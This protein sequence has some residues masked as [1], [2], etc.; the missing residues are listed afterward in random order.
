MIPILYFGTNSDY[1][2][3]FR[4]ILGEEVRFF[5]DLSEAFR[6]ASQHRG[7]PVVVFLER[8][9]ADEGLSFIRKAHKKFPGIYFVLVSRSLRPE[10]RASYLKAGISNAVN[11]EVTREHVDR[12]VGF[13]TDNPLLR[14]QKKK[15]DAEKVRTYRIPL[16]KRSFDVLTSSLA[17]LFLSPLLLLTMLAIRLESKGPVVYKSK[18]VGSN[19]KVFDFLKFRSMYTNADLALKKLGKLNQY[20]AQE[21]AQAEAEI[22]IGDDMLFGDDSSLEDQTLLISDDEIISETQ[23][24]TQTNLEN[25]QAFVKLENDPRITRVGRIIRKYSIDELPQLVNIFKGD[26]SVVGNRP[27]PLYEA[28]KLTSDEFIDRFMG[29]AGLTGLWQVEKRGEAGKLS[30]D[31]RKMLDIE[32]ARNYS[33]GLDM[34]IILKTFV[35]FIQK[36]N[37]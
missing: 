32:Y 30:A 8:K 2:D 18:R 25:Q 37:V 16:W 24:L 6:F 36:E 14:L 20:A 3:H 7:E 10:K 23:H 4:E 5:S 31:E 15:T 26:M 34:K 12:I 17:L 35:S 27:L 1:H 22:L 13:A 19:Y 29:P 33:F 9:S 21:E 28:E 11:P